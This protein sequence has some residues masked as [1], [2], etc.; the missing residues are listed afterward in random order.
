[1]HQVEYSTGTVYAHQTGSGSLKW[2]CIGFVEQSKTVWGWKMRMFSV[3]STDLKNTTGSSIYYWKTKANGGHIG[4][5]TWW[6]QWHHRKDN[7]NSKN[8]FYLKLT[9]KMCWQDFS[10]LQALNTM[11]EA[12]DW[13]CQFLRVGFRFRFS[14]LFLQFPFSL[15]FPNSLEQLWL[16]LFKL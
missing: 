9:N 12:K 13:L 14:K 10:I 4:V 2:Y 11:P 7:E 3:L 6:V 15:P 5:T 8:I 16:I 1:M